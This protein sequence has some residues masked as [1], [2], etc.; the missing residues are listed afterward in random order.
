MLSLQTLFYILQNLVSVVI[1]SALSLFGVITT[2]PLSWKLIRV[3]FPVN[4]IFVGMLVTSMFRYAN[5]CNTRMLFL[6]SIS[7][8]AL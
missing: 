1:V 6:F 5:L 4:V 8:A 7:V 2:E 3:W